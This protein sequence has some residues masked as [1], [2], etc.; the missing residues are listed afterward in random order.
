[1][2]VA[3]K[4]NGNTVIN[5]L[6]SE[7]KRWFAVYT[8]YK[9]EKFVVDL[10]AKKQIEAYVPLMSKTKRYQRKIKHYEVP[11]INCYIFVHI[12][13]DDYVKTL[14]TEYVLKFLRQ[15]K[16]LISIPV[17]EMNILKRVVGDIE[18]VTPLDGKHFEQG[19]EVEVVSGQLAGIRG[20]VVS[21][22]GRKRFVIELLNI[23]Y[24]LQ[25]DVDAG[26]LKPTIKAL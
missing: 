17:V 22:L 24:Q 14:E 18:E 9:C 3:I 21:R 7:E 6:H 4:V 13:R 11:L 10:L 25:L 16:D 20:K 2:S 23:G 12:T 26:L 19:E 1:M 5:H 15:G 8:R